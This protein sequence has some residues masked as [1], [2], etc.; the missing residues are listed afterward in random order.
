MNM[1]AFE[2]KT[3]KDMLP[4]EKGELLGHQVNLGFPPFEISPTESRKMKVLKFIEKVL[5]SGKLSPTEAGKFAGQVN[6]LQTALYGAV[7]RAA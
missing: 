4:D 7:G 1:L 3:S 2:F 6:F 5:A